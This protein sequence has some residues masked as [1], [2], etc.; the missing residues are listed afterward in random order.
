MRK[1]RRKPDDEAAQFAAAAS[2]L[3][4]EPLASLERCAPGGKVTFEFTRL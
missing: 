2:P 1:V 4:K 3:V